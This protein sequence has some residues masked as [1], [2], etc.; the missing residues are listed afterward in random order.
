MNRLLQ[1]FFRF[2]LLVSPLL[3]LAQD[4]YFN[5]LRN[6]HDSADFQ[7]PAGM[8]WSF[9][10][11]ALKIP[12]K[13][14]ANVQ[15]IRIPLD[16][17]KAEGKKLRFSVE[18]KG[19]DVLPARNE[20]NGIKFTLFAATPEG[21]EIWRGAKMPSGTFAWTEKSFVADL[22]EKLE[23]ADLILGFQDSCGTVFY[24]NVSV[25][26]LNSQVDL[27]GVMNM[28]YADEVAGDGKGGW[29]D[30]GPDND[31]RK[32]DYTK[33]LFA[34]IP[35]RVLSPKGNGGKSVL[36]LRSSRL[37]RAPEKSVVGIAPTSAKYCYLLHTLCHPFRKGSTAGILRIKGSGGEQSFELKVQRD[38]AN[39]WN[40]AVHEN[41]WPG[42]V[43]ENA[44]GGQVGFYVSRFEIRPETGRITELIFQSAGNSNQWI[45]AACTLSDQ[46][47]RPRKNEIFRIVP[48]EHWKILP[49]PDDPVI[50]ERS[51]LDRSALRLNGNT[52]A[53]MVNREGKLVQS[54]APE[55]PVRFLSGVEIWDT[56][57]GRRGVSK[58][59]LVTRQQISDHVRQL[60]RYG[61]SCVRLHYLDGI[62]NYRTSGPLE[63]DSERLKRFDYLVSV[64][65]ENGMYLNIDAMSSGYFPENP[66]GGKP[67]RNVG[68]ELYFSPEM[69]RNWIEGVRK[70]ITRVN[71]FTKTR[72][73]DEPF[74]ALATGKNEQEFAFSI[75][76]KSPRWKELIG[77]AWRTFLQKRYGSME[78]LRKSWGRRG[79][80]FRT[81][82]DIPAFT[83]HESRE[84]T[85]LGRD[86][87]RFIA[88]TEKGCLNFYR[89]ELTK[90][91]WKGL[92]AN[93]DMGKELYYS[94]VRNG[95]GIVFMHSYHAHPSQYTS[96]GSR[97]QQTSA[98][99][100][101]ANSFRSL[102]GAKLH[103]APIVAT[104]YGCVFW[105]RYRYEQAFVYGAY[106]A[107]QDFAGLTYFGPAAS[108]ISMRRINPFQSAHD[109]IAQASEFLTAYLFLRG[110][111]QTA[112]SSVRIDL[113]SSA[114]FAEG[115]TLNALHP[116]QSRLALVL[117]TSIAVDPEKA[118]ET[119][120][121]LAISAK[122][123][124][125]VITRPGY[126]RTLEKAGMPFRGD[127]LLDVLKER[128]LIPPGNRTDF[129]R[130]IYESCTGEL[131]MDC[132]R[133]FMSI[134][135]DRFQGICG[136][137]GTTAELNNLKIRTM[138][139]RGNLSLV[140]VEGKQ[141]LADAKRLVL[142]YLT[143]ARNSGM[144]FGDPEHT[145][146]RKIGGDG[147]TLLA[148]GKIALEFRN[149]NAET[150]KLY[151]LALNGE[152]RYELPLIRK[153]EIISME[154]DTAELP[155]G[156]S[157]YFELAAE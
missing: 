97:I 60:K 31:A 5:P 99:A 19:T 10:K 18:V 23:K 145:I 90:M 122:G 7:V 85:S 103:R 6:T 38:L 24:R 94:Y 62:L 93:F 8:I 117:G 16:V 25:K 155:G 13:N 129:K 59:E 140:S 40:P 47:H 77:P 127:Q 48:D 69:K 92:L 20:W 121:E 91:G 71:P 72:L 132:S 153:G 76:N 141:T 128:G 46:L 29:S 14:H 151:A 111:V 22:P 36:A 67:E 123:G 86:V 125:I 100:T 82:Q 113:D 28:A 43:W 27:S 45:V 119:P 106:A 57:F 66:W 79:D 42:A 156:P 49:R 35:F 81:F 101:G 130:E 63:F 33:K 114:M 154:I 133:H 58:P 32:F 144:E 108:S 51:A 50:R 107:L 115:R 137:A 152:R 1:M 68:F 53:L 83:I 12:L 134:N 136:E 17:K 3:S 4:V 112:K 147:P 105:N 146:L 116:I 157:L 65:K 131:Y 126:S 37:N 98:I 2:F 30:Q 41:A 143:D 96:P 139:T 110:D 9:E 88:E 34:G 142:V 75:L 44:D 80:S 61:Y 149:R 21:K 73:V 87:M 138:T 104:E 56:F 78:S 89:M 52:Q 70:V 74:F 118:P 120:A 148:T 39:W 95:S 54:G 55:H 102:N 150:M 64:L 15:V 135:T 11:N 26:P 124:S 84:T 109:P